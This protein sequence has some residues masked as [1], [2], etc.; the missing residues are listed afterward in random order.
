MGVDD[1]DQR[2]V[3]D[4]APDEDVVEFLLDVERRK[5]LLTQILVLLNGDGELRLLFVDR[6][7]FDFVKVDGLFKLEVDEVGPYGVIHRFGLELALL[8]LLWKFLTR[9][10]SFYLFAFMVHNN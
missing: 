2:V 6:S 3:V 5:N 1:F 9:F 10:Y 8:L 4:L 7:E